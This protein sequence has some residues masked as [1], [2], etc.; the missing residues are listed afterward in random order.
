MSALGKK[1]TYA[2]HKVMS[3]L[4]PKAD[5]CGATSDVRFVPEADIPGCYLP[6]EITLLATSYSSSARTIGS[7]LCP[8]ELRDRYIIQL[9][10]N[11]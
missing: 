3:A 9:K 5:M 2:T 6:G 7:L 11:L 1:Q 8:A 10:K 4:P